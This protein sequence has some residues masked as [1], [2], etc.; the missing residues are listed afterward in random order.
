MR[1]WRPLD[2][3][4]KLRALEALNYRDFRLLWYG[5]AFT[6]MATWMDSIARGWLIY[7]LTNSSFQLGLVRGVQAIPTLLLSPI[8]GSAAYL[9]SRKTQILIAQIVDGLLYAWVAVMIL[10]GDIQP[11]HVY[12]TSLG[13]ATV[14]A[15]QLPSRS[16]MVSDSV[17]PNCLTNAMG[18]NAVVFNSARSAGPALAGVLIAFYG[19]AGSYSVQA[20]FYLL[21]TVWT[22]ML[23]PEQRTSGTGRAHA[24]HG[25][26][27]GQNILE[28][29]K[30]SWKNYEVRVGLLVVSIAM[31][32]LIPFTTLLP[33]FARDILQ[34]GAAVRHPA[35][36]HGVSVRFLAPCS[37]PSSATAC[38]RGLFMIGGVG[39]YGILL[40][41]FAASSSFGL[42]MA[43]MFMIGLCHVT[44]HALLHIVIQS[45]SPSE[46]RGRTMAI[47]HMTQVILVI[48]AMFV[49]G[50]ASLIGAR[51]AATWMSV[52]GTAAMIAI[53]ALMPRARRI[54]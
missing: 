18:L 45:Y 41:I 23:R 17:P 15:F 16:S 32:L 29:W 51:W 46:F 54:K 12:V 30:F 36:L 21:A 27:F 7:E 10:T 25:E 26:S 28:G 39:L 49:G 53:Y 47:F 3:A 50:L 8:A 48:G 1:L 37:L 31:F 42:S 24:A 19:T 40:V 11:W 9:Y 38:P 35:D 13:L 6:S 34:V 52:A 14:Q 44:S 4:L 20:L 43:L 5:Q 2:A 22:I 33:V